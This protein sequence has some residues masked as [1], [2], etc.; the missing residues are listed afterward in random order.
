MSK[1]NTISKKIFLIVKTF[2]QNR[3]NSAIFNKKNL[4]MLKFNQ[5]LENFKYKSI[6]TILKGYPLL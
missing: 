6:Q 3:I 1:I 2:L 5:T 4:E